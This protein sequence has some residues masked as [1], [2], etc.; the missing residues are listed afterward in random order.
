MPDG[1]TGL[2]GIDLDLVLAGD[3]FQSEEGNK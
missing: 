2:L 1:V 3:Q